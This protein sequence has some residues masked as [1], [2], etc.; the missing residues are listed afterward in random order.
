MMTDRFKKEESAAERDFINRQERELLK[1]LLKR[2]GGA[3]AHK[4]SDDALATV[5]AKHKVNV[6]GLAEDLKAWKDSH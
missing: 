6:P 3:D 2:V 5:L 4:A 1:S